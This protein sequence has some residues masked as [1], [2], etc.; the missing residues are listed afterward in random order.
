MSAREKAENFNAALNANP[1][2]S[3]Q[4]SRGEGGSVIY[5]HVKTKGKKYF[6]KPTENLQK[7]LDL[8]LLRRVCLEYFTL[9]TVTKN[10]RLTLTVPYSLKCCLGGGRAV[11]LC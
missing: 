10:K 11:F 4:E 7:L 3:R 1:T 2:Q 8:F 9:M 6:D 5:C